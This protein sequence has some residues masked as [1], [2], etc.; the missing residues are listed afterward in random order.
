VLRAYDH[1]AGADEPLVWYE[2]VPGGVSRRYLHADHQ[3]S[4][5]AVADQNGNPIAVNAYDAW[6]IPNA[7]NLGRFGYT[8]QAWLPELGLWYYKA[9]LYSPTLGRF[10]QIDPIGYKDQIHLYAY[11]GNDPVTNLDHNGKDC[12]SV[13]GVTTCT[14]DVYQVS[15]PTQPGWHDFTKGTP[16]YHFYSTPAHSDR[17]VAETRQ[18]VQSYPTPGAPDPATKQGTYNDATPGSSSNRFAISPV[19]SFATI[20]HLTGNPVVVSVTLPGHPLKDGIVVREVTS[21]G[22]GQSMIHNWGEGDSKLQS[23]DTLEG[24]VFGPAINGV[25]SNLVPITSPTATEE[26]SR[27]NAFCNTHPGAC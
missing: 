13:N 23:P 11:V 4:I 12:S 20:N 6:G 16:D 19:R 24:K 8:G 18:W 26:T 9:R 15:F 27:Q 21:D 5:V 17:S 10:L 22:H 14:T 2:A 1:G 7:S 3:G 25:W